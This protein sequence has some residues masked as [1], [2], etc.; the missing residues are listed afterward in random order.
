MIDLLNVFTAFSSYLSYG[1]SGSTSILCRYGSTDFIVEGL[2]GS[3]SVKCSVQIILSN[4]S[5]ISCQ[6][7]IYNAPFGK[8]AYVFAV[9]NEHGRARLLVHKKTW[10]I[11]TLQFTVH[12]Q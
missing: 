6:L 5:F 10:Q 11:F 9:V 8:L 7:F 2:M 12:L 4:I 1:S 3:V